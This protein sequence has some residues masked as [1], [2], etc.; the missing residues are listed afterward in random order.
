MRLIVLIPSTFTSVEK[1]RLL[2]ARIIGE[3]A[4]FLGMY[5]VTHVIVYHDDDPYFDSHALGKYTV[6]TLKYAVTP[7]WLKKEAFPIRTTDRNWGAIPPLQ[8]RSHV[9]P[10]KIRWAVWRDGKAFD[11]KEEWALS[12]TAIKRAGIKPIS[13]SL[14]PVDRRRAL[15]VNQLNREQYIGFWP[16]YWNVGLHKA[17]ERLRKRFG[18]VYVVGTTRHG[19]RAERAMHGYERGRDMALVFGGHHRGILEMPDYRESDYNGLMNL[20]ERQE[21][22]T[23][24]TEEAVPLV[25]EQ[26][27]A[28]GYVDV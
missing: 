21:T 26:L 20:F 19:E 18:D 27:H 12:E 10:G 2:R 3:L 24:R 6:K 22:K 17:I 15:N 28:K 11:G 16:E 14:I 8:I 1:N 9:K 13:P 23:V 25:L 5:R 4:R 7:P